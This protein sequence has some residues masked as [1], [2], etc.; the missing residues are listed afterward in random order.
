MAALGFK[1]EDY[2]QPP[3]EC[4]VW[5]DNWRAVQ[6]FDRISLGCWTFRGQD[7]MGLRYESLRDIRQVLKVNGAEWAGGLFDDIQV[8]ENEAVKVMRSIE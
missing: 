4:L 7:V 1:P 5:P 8:M 3:S 6:F 2:P